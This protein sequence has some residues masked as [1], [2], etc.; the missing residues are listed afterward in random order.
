LLIG[1][2]GSMPVA[3]PISILITSNALKGEVKYCNLVT[4][5]A[6]L[7]DFLYVFAAVFGLTKFYSLYKPVIPYVLLI[8]A[9]FLVYLGYKI[10]KTKINLNEV[11]N[12]KSY[13]KIKRKER[14][15]FLTGFLLNFLNPTLFLSWLTTSFIVISMVTSL[16]F[17][18]G[19]FDKSVDN[20]FKT[21]NTQEKGNALNRKNKAITYLKIDSSKVQKHEPTA[22]QIAKQPIYFTLLLS[23]FYA[24]FLSVGGIAWFF[25][26][27]FLLA[28]YRQQININIVNGLIQV[29]GVAL[30]LFGLFLGY[31]GITLFIGKMKF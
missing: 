29:L 21:I 31:K 15:A 17:S 10:T 12:R 30:C 8:G 9:V 22:A 19:G 7:A 11:G 23:V 4:I 25:L 5:G 18:T 28:K 24:C 16:G 2:I 1:F 14:S 27:A 6:S 26:L 20:S 13:A 3:G